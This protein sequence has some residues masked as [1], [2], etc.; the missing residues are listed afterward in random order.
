MRVLVVDDEEEQRDLLESLLRKWG[1]TVTTASDGS[2]G[3]AL[4]PEAR[5]QVMI[6]DLHMPKIDGFQL[7]EKLRA[8]Q[9]LPPTIVLTAFGNVEIAVET[10]HKYGAF[11]FLEKPVNSDSLRLLVDRAAAQASL[12]ADNERLR[13]ELAQRGVL[14]D[15]VGDSK[16]MQ[17]IYSLIRRVAPTDA[18]V[19]ITGESGSGK[20]LVARAIHTNSQRAN[21]AFLAINCAA[22]PETLM[23]SEIFGHEKGAFTGALDRKAGA[24][25]LAEGGTLFLDEIGEM[26]MPMQAKLL[27]VLEDFRF[28]RLGGKVELK[29]NVRLLSATNRTPEDAI[30]ENKLREDLYY[31]LN[32]FHIELPPLRERPEDIPLIA[33]SMIERFNQRY[34]TRVTHISSEATESL[35]KRPWKGNVR[36]LRNIVERAVI[37]AAEGPIEERHLMIRKEQPAEI[38]GSASNGLAI[39]VGMTIDE[40][41]RVLIEATLRQT[42]NNKTRAAAVLGISAKTLHVKLR[43]YRLEQFEQEHEPEDQTAEQRTGG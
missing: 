31:R 25:E 9:A 37:L 14:G 12:A 4:V 16:P 36:E 7:M 20:E 27:R 42:G 35:L 8:E 5:P 24:L 2:E 32:V 26:P 3:L 19:M 43:Q 39:N 15:L 21:Q 22:M 30:K 11:W 40:A 41:E 10:V 28:R 13:L 29:A 1:H 18:C 6:T 17:A 38:P 33:G 23:E 34:S